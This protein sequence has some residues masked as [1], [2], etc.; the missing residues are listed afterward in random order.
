EALDEFRR[1]S[2][3]ALSFGFSGKWTGIPE[4]SALAAELFRIGE[5][6]V[7]AAITEARAFIQVERAGRGATMMDGTMVDRATDRVNSSVLKTAFALGML[8]EDLA[9]EL[10]IK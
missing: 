9:A 2:E 3:L 8:D 5:Q 7:S 4:Q 6:E 1:D 10:G